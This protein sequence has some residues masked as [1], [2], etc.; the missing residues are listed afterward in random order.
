HAMPGQLFARAVS[1]PPRK[2]VRSAAQT[3]PPISSPPTLRKILVAHVPSNRPKSDYHA[4]LPKIRMLHSHRFVICPGTF[5]EIPPGLHATGSP[6]I[7]TAHHFW[8]GCK[9]KDNL[10][11]FCLSNPG[12]NT[13]S[14]SHRLAGSCRPANLPELPDTPVSATR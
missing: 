7:Q 5:S 4:I 2:A 3:T 1:F 6:A 13:E 14:A 8:A 9:P 11:G 12:P 10:A